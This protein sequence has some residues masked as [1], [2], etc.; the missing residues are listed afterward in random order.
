MALTASST[1]VYTYVVFAVVYL[2]SS[3]TFVVSAL[4]I[5]AT[6]SRSRTTVPSSDTSH[7]PA[8]ASAGEYVSRS[9]RL[10]DY[11]Q[12][13]TMLPLVYIVGSMFL[14]SLI[15]NGQGPRVIN[16]A[17]VAFTLIAAAA[18]VTFAVLG[19]RESLSLGGV[20]DV[21]A[22]S[23]RAA[24]VFQ[25]LGIRLGVSAALLLLVAVFT[26]L[27]LLSILGNVDSLLGIQYVL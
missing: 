8:R 18:A 4:R 27:N 22:S 9:Q 12:L 23:G 20:G 3:V 17:W 7:S 5:S 16:I 26:M 24:D 14:G 21:M 13:A 25:R 6:L 1:Y 19:T 15:L 11:T 2:V 10:V